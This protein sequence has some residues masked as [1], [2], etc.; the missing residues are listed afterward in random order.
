MSVYRLAVFLHIVGAL[1]FAAALAL[2]W[3]GLHFVRRAAE[4][5]SIREW[6]KLLRSVRLV[7]GPSLLAVLISGMFLT[8]TRW[9]MQGW[10]AA[11]LVGLVVIGALG[12]ALSGRRMAAIGRA[13][14]TGDG[15]IP[16]GLT[17]QLRDPVLTLS[18]TLRTSLALG[19]VY[20]M[21]AKPGG[22]EAF[23]TLGTFLALAL[24]LVLVGR[25]AKRQPETAGPRATG[26]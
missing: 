7:G 22:R 17:D 24:G 21:S 15:P 8:S 4:S 18:L 20:L 12:G 5:G 25:M 9:G 2:E 14:P 1:G 23:L 19:I 10:I 11:G 3:A 26:A 13:I 6:A 16:P